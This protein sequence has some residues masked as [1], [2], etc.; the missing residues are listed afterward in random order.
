L[1]AGS[2]VGRSLNEIVA[3]ISRIT[4]C[5]IDPVFKPGRNVDV[6][7]SV[8]DVSR[9]RHALGWTAATDF[10][11]ALAKTWDWIRKTD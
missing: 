8:L 11:A 10:D 1:N 2:G 7:W 6:P 3:A 5:R 9:A 4:G